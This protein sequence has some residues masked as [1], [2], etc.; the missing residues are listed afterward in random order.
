MA[1][2]PTLI[3]DTWYNPDG[4]LLNANCVATP[5]PAPANEG[6]TSLA[7]NSVSFAVVNGVVNVSLMPN[8][9]AQPLGTSYSVYV[10]LGRGKSFTDTWY[11]W[12]SNT[13]LTL[14]QVRVTENGLPLSVQFSTAS[15]W[16]IP[17]SLCFQIANGVIPIVQLF[18]SNGTPIVANV[19]INRQGD[20]DL[21]VN[22]ATPQAGYAQVWFTS[23]QYTQAIVGA[24]T[25]TL[26]A[27]TMGLQMVAG[28]TVIDQNGNY[29][30][31]GFSMSLEFG[32]GI[33][34]S[35]TFTFATPQS[36]TVVVL[37]A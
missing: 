22:F 7:P 17:A 26:A 10:Y 20:G 5:S 12:T 4:S 8:D 21:V 32:V 13:P 6:S 3:S 36:G 18:E 29:V 24:T 31:G 37:G 1:T 35:V 28:A 15:T 11:V 16:L 25:V 2:S 27:S 34:S 19:V 30:I 23:K 9:A 14:A 33:F